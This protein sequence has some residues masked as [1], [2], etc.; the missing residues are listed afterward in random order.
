MPPD[1]GGADLALGQTVT[2]LYEIVPTDGGSES[3][4]LVPL[5]YQDGRPSGPAHSREWFTVKLRYK[6][7]EG[8]KSSEV[9][10]PC[11]LPALA[12]SKAPEDFQFAAS[13]G[14]FGM[15]LRD[16]PHCGSADYE[17]VLEWAGQNNGE[18]ERGEFLE[19]V[20]RAANLSGA[21]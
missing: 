13:V 8:A 6:E 3:G 17:D 12:F 1:A 11:A 4:E 15:L 9:A 18:G 16:S 19:L 21:S 20:R 10:F 7:P 5:R 14:A 2:A